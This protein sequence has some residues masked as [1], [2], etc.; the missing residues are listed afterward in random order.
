MRRLV[1]A[2]RVQ[3]NWSQGLLTGKIR[4]AFTVILLVIFLQTIFV[5]GQHKGDE[6]CETLPSEIHLIK[7]ELKHSAT[8][9]NNF[10]EVN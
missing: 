8:N 2:A 1:Y 10:G 5:V 9:S 4:T 6:I 7:G 3:P